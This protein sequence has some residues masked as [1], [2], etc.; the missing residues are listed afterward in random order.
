MLVIRSE[1][2][3]SSRV[4]QIHLWGRSGVILPGYLYYVGM[5]CSTNHHDGWR[6]TICS[7]AFLL[8]KLSHKVD[9]LSS[10]RE[11]PCWTCGQEGHKSNTCPTKHAETCPP[12]PTYPEWQHLA[13]T[14]GASETL[15]CNGHTFF[16][17]A[18]CSHWRT[19]LR[20][21]GCM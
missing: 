3:R 8:E 4:V 18:T 7:T 16:W 11:G 10:C 9:L 12:P 19:T 21:Q 6:T 20:G 14:M 5:S 2:P 15:I 17:C 13:P 1:A